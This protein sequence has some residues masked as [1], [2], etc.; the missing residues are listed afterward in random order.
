MN[1]NSLYNADSSLRGTEAI[2]LHPRYIE[3][4]RTIVLTLMLILLLGLF[5]VPM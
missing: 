1:V 4:L 2:L 5:I 3:G